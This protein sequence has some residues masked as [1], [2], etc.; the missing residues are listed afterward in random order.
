MASDIYNS[1]TQ[2]V[3]KRP[4]NLLQCHHLSNSVPAIRRIGRFGVILGFETPTVR[5]DRMPKSAPK[6][7]WGLGVK[8]AQ[9]ISIGRV[10]GPFQLGVI[11]AFFDFRAGRFFN[12][13][14][15]FNTPEYFDSSRFNCFYLCFD[16]GGI[17]GRGGMPTSVVRYDVPVLTSY[18]EV[19]PRVLHTNN[20]R[21]ERDINSS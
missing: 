11:S 10:P 19:M 17:G 2:E 5:R 8:R 7:R 16:T 4:E 15:V 1:N 18:V 13:L 9:K 12:N 14:L 6:F 21:S 3:C 20:H